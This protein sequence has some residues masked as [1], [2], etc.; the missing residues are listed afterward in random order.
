MLLPDAILFSKI[1]KQAQNWLHPIWG[2]IG[3][4]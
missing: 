4:Q 3:R 2:E 1:T